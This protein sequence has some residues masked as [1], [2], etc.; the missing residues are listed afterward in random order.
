MRQSLPLP[1]HCFTHV[2]PLSSLQLHY[3]FYFLTTFIQ[4]HQN[5]PDD[6]VFCLSFLHSLTP[7]FLIF[8]N[9]KKF[10]VLLTIFMFLIFSF[11][12]KKGV[13]GMVVLLEEMRLV[14]M[15]PQGFDFH[16][17]NLLRYNLSKG[18]GL[19]KLKLRCRFV[20]QQ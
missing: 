7:K 2:T 17:S 3:C 8:I 15:V 14:G 12:H 6:S 13:M 4:L 18:V 1:N 9:M 16:A 20:T 10:N 11:P 19:N 5:F